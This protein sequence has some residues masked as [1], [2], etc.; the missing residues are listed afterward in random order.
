[1]SITK[2]DV[3]NQI[4]YLEESIAAKETQVSELQRKITIERNA[5]EAFKRLP[6]EVF[7]KSA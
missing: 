1:M 2:A 4:K 6:E 7:A 5:M 3:A